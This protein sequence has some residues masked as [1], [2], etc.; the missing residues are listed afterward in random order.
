VL[1]QIG[2]FYWTL[3]DFPP[4]LSAKIYN[5]YL[6]ALVWDDSLSN[7]EHVKKL[8]NL[9][10]A[11]GSDINLFNREDGYT[12]ET[13]DG[14][15]RIH[16]NL[17]ALLADTPAAALMCARSKSVSATCFC[18]S[19]NCHLGQHHLPVRSHWASLLLV[20]ACDVIK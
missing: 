13:A 16:A 20:F 2:F 9:P 8:M 15:Q 4:H 19:C 7:P 12:L 18:R 11:L 6:A 17:F 1:V 14:P 5:I 3:A 10:H